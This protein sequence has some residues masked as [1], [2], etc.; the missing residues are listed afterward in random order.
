MTSTD[1]HGADDIPHDHPCWPIACDCGYAFQPGDNWQHNSH[2]LWRRAS[3][4]SE[5]PHSLFL[6]NHNQVLRGE[7]WTRPHACGATTAP[8]GSL[9]DCLWYKSIKQWQGDDGRSAEV[10]LPDGC[11]WLIDG[12]S[13]NGDGWDRS[14]SWPR[15]TARPS[16]FTPGYHGFLTDGVLVPC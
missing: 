2:R 10:V 8:P 5:Q 7:L 13:N 14:G 4:P 1:G 11:L 15:I 6:F 16:I 12:P 3:D 9:R